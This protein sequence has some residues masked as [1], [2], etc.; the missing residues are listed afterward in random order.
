MK[1]MMMVYVVTRRYDFICIY[2]NHL[3]KNKRHVIQILRTEDGLQWTLQPCVE[4]D[5]KAWPL[6]YEGKT[7]MSF[8]E[9]DE[10]LLLFK[11]NV[12]VTPS[13][14]IPHQGF[15]H[16]VDSELIGIFVRNLASF[17]DCGTV[18]REM[19]DCAEE[20]TTLFILQDED[21]RNRASR[22]YEMLDRPNKRRLFNCHHVSAEKEN[23]NEG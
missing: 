16:H 2:L 13:F 1:S 7:V 14:P 22:W 17:D 19:Y 8:E 4:D 11:N 3:V 6:R 21:L 15:Q 10:E 18:C 5:D 23:E 9:R 12:V 20:K